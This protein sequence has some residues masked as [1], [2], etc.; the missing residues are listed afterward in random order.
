MF[1]NKTYR[2]RLEECETQQYTSNGFLASSAQAAIGAS[3][4][5]CTRPH[6]LNPSATNRAACIADAASNVLEL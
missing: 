4:L 5:P 6:S 1:I 3:T 2:L